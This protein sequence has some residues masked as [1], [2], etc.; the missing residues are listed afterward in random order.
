MQ[1]KGY[2][3]REPDI[4]VTYKVPRNKIT[5][6][7]IGTIIRAF[8]IVT[9]ESDDPKMVAACKGDGPFWKFDFVVPAW[10]AKK[11]E[12]FWGEFCKKMEDLEKVRLGG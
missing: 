10:W 5:K 2:I 7:Q 1:G 11:Y 4:Q 8:A 12:V 3:G 6:E 9:E